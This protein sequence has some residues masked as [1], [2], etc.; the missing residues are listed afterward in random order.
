MKATCLF[1][2]SG[3]NTSGLVNCIMIASASSV[4]PFR[5]NHHGAKNNKKVER[6]SDE[7]SQDNMGFRGLH[8]GA[9]QQ[10]K[11]KVNHYQKVVF[12]K[13]HHKMTH[14]ISKK[15]GQ[16]NWIVNGNLQPDY[17]TRREGI[18]T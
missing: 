1:A 4:R 6:F 13:R 18:S 14:I 8:S 12:Q 9:N 15:G 7:L 2:I 16:T 10:L 3:V 5:T 17:H 11:R